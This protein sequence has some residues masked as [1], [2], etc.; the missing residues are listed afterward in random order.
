MRDL[1][2]E[3]M[4]E[5]RRKYGNEAIENDFVRSCLVTTTAIINSKSL[6]ESRSRNKNRTWKTVV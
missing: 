5:K 6:R 3:Y 4:H 1:E 2:A